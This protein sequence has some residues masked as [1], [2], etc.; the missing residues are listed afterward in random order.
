MPVG[1][2]CFKEG[3]RMCAEVYHKLKEILK[4][5]GLSAAV[6]DEGGF[7]PDLKGAEEALEYM[8]RAVKEARDLYREKKFLL[9]LMWQQASSMKTVCIIFR[10]RALCEAK[11]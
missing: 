1:A 9:L 7:A 11:K 10:D 3:L 2:C 5:E 4:S 8:V 6:G